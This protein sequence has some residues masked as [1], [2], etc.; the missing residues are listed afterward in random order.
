MTQKV[1]KAAIFSV[2]TTRVVRMADGSS[3]MDHGPMMVYLCAGPRSSALPLGCVRVMGTNKTAIPDELVVDEAKLKRPRHCMEC[4]KEL[5]K[6]VVVCTRC[7][8]YIVCGAKCG[9]QGAAKHRDGC[10]EPLEP[11]A[12]LDKRQVRELTD[13]IKQTRGMCCASPDCRNIT[14]PVNVASL[15]I[16]SAARP[17]RKIK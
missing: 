12:S 2:E 11:V 4:N 8:G 9:R 15:L 3:I 1:N 13:A 5:G 16:S 14:D 7:A 6:L 17:P 10:Y